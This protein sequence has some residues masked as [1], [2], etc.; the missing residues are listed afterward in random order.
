MSCYDITMLCI[1]RLVGFVRGFLPKLL[2]QN[3]GNM[4]IVS[5]ENSGAVFSSICF[6]YDVT[7]I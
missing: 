7:T 1:S 3:Y 4:K 2:L 6:C 5:N